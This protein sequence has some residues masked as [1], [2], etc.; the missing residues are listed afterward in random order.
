MFKI[1]KNSNFLS[2]NEASDDAELFIS[3]LLIGQWLFRKA[4]LTRNHLTLEL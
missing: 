2:I 3:G 1:K 4:E